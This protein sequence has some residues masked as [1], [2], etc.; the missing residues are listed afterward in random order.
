MEKAEE[1]EEECTLASPPPPPS[2]R[3]HKLMEDQGRDSPKLQEATFPKAEKHLFLK[4][5]FVNI[6]LLKLKLGEFRFGVRAKKREKASRSVGRKDDEGEWLLG[7]LS[8]N[9]SP[10][11]S[12]LF[13]A[14]NQRAI[15]HKQGGKRRKS[16]ALFVQFFARSYLPFTRLSSFCIFHRLFP[17]CPRR[18][19]RV[20]LHEKMG[21]G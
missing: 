13:A 2:L 10:H 21:G 19:R 15:S 3:L 4:E 14:T 1:K 9:G 7:S 16:S 8:G 5:L 20:Q 6:G 12:L 18:R 11:S 17:F